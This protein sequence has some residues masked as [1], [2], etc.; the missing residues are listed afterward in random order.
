MDAIIAQIEEC[1]MHRLDDDAYSQLQ[2]S[3]RVKCTKSDAHIL[4]LAELWTEFGDPRAKELLEQLPQTLAVQ[5]ALVRYDMRVDE[6]TRA[7]A[8]LLSLRQDYKG[9]KNVL[10]LLLE[11]LDDG[12]LISEVLNELEELNE[13]Y[14]LD[15]WVKTLLIDH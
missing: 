7:C 5:L 13:P 14:D 15:T 6:R 10:L 3:D 2:L 9:N 1:L 12:T 8:R 11:V 4:R